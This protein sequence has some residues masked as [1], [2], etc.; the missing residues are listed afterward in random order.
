MRGRCGLADVAPFTRRHT[1]ARALLLDAATIDAAV[2]AA[3]TASRGLA[4]LAAHTPPLQLGSHTA[5]RLGGVVQAPMVAGNAWPTRP[6]SGFGVACCGG[7]GG[8]GGA[9]SSDLR[10]RRVSQL[11][12]TGLARWPSFGR[13]P[14]QA[15]S[16]PNPQPQPQPH[17]VTPPHARE[18]RTGQRVAE[19]GTAHR[20]CSAFCTTGM[21]ANN[22]SNRPSTA[23]PRSLLPVAAPDIEAPTRCATV[24]HS[25]MPWGR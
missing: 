10:R 4:A 3:G 2:L 20:T 19:A 7:C 6:R 1:A 5:V 9:S 12:A 14:T 11:R 25:H 16:L 23:L 24:S 18:G 8:S 21:R 22:A 15:H 17:T 13:L